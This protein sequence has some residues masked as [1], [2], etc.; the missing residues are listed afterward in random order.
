MKELYDS[1]T[2]FEYHLEL[3]YVKHSSSPTCMLRDLLENAAFLSNIVFLYFLAALPDFLTVH[4]QVILPSGTAAWGMEGK[5]G[6]SRGPDQSWQKEQKAFCWLNWEWSTRSPWK[7][8]CPCKEGRGISLLGVSGTRRCVGMRP[9]A[10]A[11][12][13]FGTW[14]PFHSHRFAPRAFAPFSHLEP[15]LLY[16]RL[17]SARVEMRVSSIW[18]VLLWKSYLVPRL[19]NY[20]REGRWLGSSLGCRGSFRD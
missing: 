5:L 3:S 15:Y 16:A 13:Q 11:V 4:Y 19:R 1:M 18:P 12:S 20:F 10:W 14:Q 7:E 17:S 9:G 6:D 2:C 8:A